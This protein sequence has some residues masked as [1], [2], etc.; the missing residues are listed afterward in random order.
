MG[1]V[2]AIS[3]QVQQLDG[4]NVFAFKE[5]LHHEPP[6]YLKTNKYRDMK[7]E[8][9]MER[10]TTTENMLEQVQETTKTYLN[11]VWFRGEEKF[12]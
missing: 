1:V 8:E 6:S 3:N 9:V 2:H 7:V 5:I 12:F 11:K 10:V 4:R